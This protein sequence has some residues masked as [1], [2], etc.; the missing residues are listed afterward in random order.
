MQKSESETL[1][2]ECNENSAEVPKMLTEYSLVAF[3]LIQQGQY[4]QSLELLSQSEELLEAVTSQGGSVDLDF[5]L[6]TVH[7]SAYCYS[8]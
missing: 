6:L 8:K 4:H 7:N 2:S 1:I 5:I 3:A